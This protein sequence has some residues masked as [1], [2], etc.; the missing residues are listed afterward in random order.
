MCVLYNQAITPMGLSDLDNRGKK[1]TCRTVLEKG[2]FP[3]ESRLAQHVSSV[4]FARS[5]FEI[6]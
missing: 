4:H 2:L 6:H 3:F 5:Q 1:C